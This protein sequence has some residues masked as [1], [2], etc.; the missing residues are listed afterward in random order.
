[1]LL[2]LHGGKGAPVRKCDEH[3]TLVAE[4][5][6]MKLAYYGTL[7]VLIKIDFVLLGILISQ[8]A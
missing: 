4:F 8:F 1:M 7:A 5:R 6:K 2:H 3:D